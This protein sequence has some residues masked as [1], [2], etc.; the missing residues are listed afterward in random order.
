M[1]V[2]GRC[3]SKL[4]PASF[5]KSAVN[6]DGLHSWC[7]KCAVEANRIRSEKFKKDNLAKKA[8]AKR[9]T[10]FKCKKSKNPS[11]FYIDIT[12]KTGLSNFCKDCSKKDRKAYGK[13]KSREFQE[14][15]K[16]PDTKVCPQCKRKLSSTQFNLSRISYD[17]LSSRCSECASLEKLGLTLQQYNQ[18]L[19]MQNG[20]CAV[21]QIVE[22]NGHGRFHVDHDHSCC[23][24]RM[25][26]GNCAL[27]LVCSKCNLAMGSF[28]D[29][30]ELLKKASNYLRKWSNKG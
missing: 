28:K 9:Q 16:R 27:G 2:C 1:K 15:A 20:K 21:C 22:S 4:P 6:K 29:S 24:G 10:C 26:C 5:S 30:P 12:R 23:P 14:G 13:K 7:K 25:K 18:L 17:G 3:K 11:S 19:E 8:P